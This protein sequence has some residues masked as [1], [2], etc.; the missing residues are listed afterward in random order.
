MR[1]SVL[2]GTQHP[3]LSKTTDYALRALLVLARHGAGRPMSADAIADLTG[4]PPNYTSKTLYALARAGLLRSMR[5]PSGGFS[6]AVPPGTITIAQIMDVF[7]DPPA[8]PRCL[9]GARACDAENPCAAHAHWT[10]VT[11]AAREPLNTTTVADLLVDA[12][13]VEER[14]TEVRIPL[15]SGA[16]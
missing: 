6:L 14:N 13:P 2:H 1:K 15:R 11:S 4:T 12:E 3:V 9:M 5:G 16:A 7:A 8:H 10:R